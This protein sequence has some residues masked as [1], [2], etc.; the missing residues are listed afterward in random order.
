MFCIKKYLYT[1]N[2]MKNRNK[3]V[4]IKIIGDNSFLPADVQSVINKANEITNEKTELYVN[5]C[6]GYSGKNEIVNATKNIINDIVD[7]KLSID[8]IN[9]KLFDS[10]LY[11]KDFPEVDLLIRTGGDKRISG[12]LLWKISYAE[13]YFCDKYWPSF[14]EEQFYLALYIFQSRNMRYGK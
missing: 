14:D 4:K 6:I 10:Y 5:L 13:L 9:E 11:T 3:N 2:I 7:K 1:D 8:M 12:F